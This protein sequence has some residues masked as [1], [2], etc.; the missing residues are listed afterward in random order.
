M[1]PQQQEDFTR[2][3]DNKEV[4]PLFG[5]AEEELDQALAGGFFPFS[6]TVR[7]ILA[8]GSLS[9]QAVRD[10]DLSLFSTLIHGPPGSGKTGNMGISDRFGFGA[11][12]AVE[13]MCRLLQRRETQ[14]SI[15]ID[16]LPFQLNHYP[17]SQFPTSIV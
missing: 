3:L 7:R 11:T 1:K 9:A 6:D 8:E 14:I 4:V 12:D 13:G 17:I 2:A 10:G 16:P 5:V 15:P